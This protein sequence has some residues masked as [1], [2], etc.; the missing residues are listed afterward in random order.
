MRLQAAGTP[1]RLS[2]SGQY[3]RVAQTLSGEDVWMLKGFTVP[4]SPLGIAAWLPSPPWHLA[5]DI[6]GRRVLE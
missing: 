1:P 3:R 2:F 6:S 4:L 5:G